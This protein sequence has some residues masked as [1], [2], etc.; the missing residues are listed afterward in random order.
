MLRESL[1]S[2]SYKDVTDSCDSCWAGRFRI[3]YQM[4]DIGRVLIIRV[5]HEKMDFAVNGM[6]FAS[7]EGD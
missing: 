7:V 3:F 5:L 6:Y 4:Q 1:I 2:S